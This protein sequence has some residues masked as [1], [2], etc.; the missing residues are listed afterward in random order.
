MLTFAGVLLGD[1]LYIDGGE[2]TYGFSGNVSQYPYNSTYALDLSTSWSPETATFHKIDKGSSP[3][4]NT[5]NL[6]PSTDNKSFYLFN[7]DITLAG[8]HRADPPKVPELWQFTPNGITQGSWRRTGFASSLIGV[9][10]AKSTYGEGSV[11]ILG[12]FAFDRSSGAVADIEAKPGLVSYDMSTDQ[13]QN[14]SMTPY[15][16]VGSA[17]DGSLHFVNNLGGANG[18]VIAFGGVVLLSS[19]QFVDF[20]TVGLFNPANGQWTM[21]KTTG[22]IPPSRRLACSAGV[23]G[24]DGTYEVR[25]L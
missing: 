13:W 5:P 19:Q 16:P 10:R 21:Q 14:R 7:G 9:T 6:W 11:H 18:L 20:E 3:I 23:A 12:G 8:Q 2:F 17:I 22:E 1:T 25:W 4:L 24:K 15:I